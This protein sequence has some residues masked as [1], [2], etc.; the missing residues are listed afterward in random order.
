MGV[1]P[2]TVA[3]ATPMTFSQAGDLESLSEM[4]CG[5]ARGR[6]GRAGTLGKG[7]GTLL[8]RLHPA[9]DVPAA[10]ETVRQWSTFSLASEF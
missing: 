10:S 4:T 2:Y 8:P 3:P 1:T 6:P 7:R 9:A 5:L